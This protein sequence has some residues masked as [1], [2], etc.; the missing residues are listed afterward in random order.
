MKKIK[1]VG[2]CSKYITG[3]GWVTEVKLQALI[4]LLE[5]EGYKVIREKK[6]GK[7]ED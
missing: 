1:L 5:K 2:P 6:D 3:E 4:E 7:R